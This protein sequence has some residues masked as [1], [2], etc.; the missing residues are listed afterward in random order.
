MPRVVVTKNY[1]WRKFVETPPSPSPT[2]KF[3]INELLFIY[4]R[5]KIL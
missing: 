4:K 5:S 3:D 2:Q 1:N